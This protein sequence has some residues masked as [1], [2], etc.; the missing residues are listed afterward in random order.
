MHDEAADG[1]V[2]DVLLDLR[3]VVRDVVDDRELAR[4]GTEHPREDVASPVG[5]ELAVGE[6]EVR[7]RPHGAE[8]VARLR[9]VV[10]RARE[11]AVGHADAVPAKRL[12]RHVEV[13][14]AHLMA[15]AT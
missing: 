13:V 11:L 9:R 1:A 8:I 6:R 5:Q 4:V 7:G 2:H 3:D 10:R 14:G 15:E 12:A